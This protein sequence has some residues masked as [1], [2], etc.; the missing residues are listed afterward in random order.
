MDPKT[1]HSASLAYVPRSEIDR[2]LSLKVDRV[3]RTT[4]FAA[5]ARLNTLYMI[6]RAGSGHIG[7]SFSSLDLVSWIYLNGLRAEPGSQESAAGRRF[8][9]IY[10]SSKGHDVPGC[11]SVFLGLGL[12]DFNLIHELRRIGGLPGHP[13]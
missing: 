10:F 12:L 2:V 11:Y 4:I 8:H 5:L 1:M 13:D 7:S 9:D 3:T 6:K